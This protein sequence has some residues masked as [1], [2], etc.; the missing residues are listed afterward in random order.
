MIPN[1]YKMAGELLPAVFHVS[2]RAVAG[3]ALSIFGDHQDVMAVRQTGFGLLASGSVQ[4]AHDM[5]LAAHLCALE[6]SVPFLHFFEGFRVSHEIQKIK[7]LEYGDM[8]GLVDMDKVAAFRARAM[9]PEH[10]DIRGTAQNPD[11]YFQGREAANPYYASLP[12]TVARCLARVSEATGRAYGLFDYVGHPEATD[13][14]VAMGSACETI[15]EAVSHLT[16]QGRRIGLVKVRLYRPFASA[17]FLESLQP[18]PAGC[19]S[20]TAPRSPEP[21]ASPC[22]STCAMPFSRRAWGS[23]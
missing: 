7:V 10:P 19:R 5:A 22:T 2:A 17:S 14:V 11:I 3:H 15:E 18:R 8:A 4:E 16:A 20:S 13:V 9:N 12:D 23:G 21:R 6:S 1:M